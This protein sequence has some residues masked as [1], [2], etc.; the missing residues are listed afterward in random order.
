MKPGKPIGKRIMRSKI[1]SSIKALLKA[2]M[3]PD[4]SIRTLVIFIMYGIMIVASFFSAYLLRF[5]FNFKILG[6][7][8][9][10]GFLFVVLAVK[11]FYLLI[12]GQFKGLMTF[13][14]I[15]DVIKIFW[16]MMFSAVTLLALNYFLFFNAGVPIIPRGVILSD[17][18]LSMVI[19][20]SARI[21]MRMYRERSMVEKGATHSPKR[22]MIIGA[23]DIGTS[24]AADLIARK[25]LGILPVLFLDDDPQKW[26]KQIMGIEVAPLEGNMSNFVSGFKIDRAIIASVRF[27]GQRISKIISA[28]HKIGIETSIV[29]SYHDLASGRVKAS[30][31][32]DVDIEDV[33][34]REPVK[35]DDL[36]IDKMI[37]GKIVMVTGAGGSIGRELCRQIASK[38]PELLIMVDH[39]EVQLFQV[40]QEILDYEFGAKIK[41]LVGNV[42]DEAR[43]EAVISK[44]RP[45]IIFHAAAHKHVPMMESQPGEALK[46]N[47][48]GTWILAGVASRNNVEKFLLIST[49]KAINPTN[50]MGASKRLAEKAIQAMQSR[51][52]NKTIF[53]AVRF[54]NVLGSSGSVIP[55]FKK[56]ISYGGP[57]TVTH[58]EVT[59]YFMTIPEAVGLVLQCA[60]Q[61]YGG[62]IFVLNMGEPVKVIDLARQLIRLSG[63]EPDVD[64]QIKIIG[65]R[66]GE[67]LYEEIQHKNESLVDTPNP[68]IYGFVSEMP[69][70]GEVE[71]IISDIKK[72][73]DTKSVNEL[74]RF[75]F[76]VVPEYKAQFY[77]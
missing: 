19:F 50:V 2:Q 36:A 77:D 60:A 44:Y 11:Y 18:L 21:V 39:C 53:V 45:N 28:L 29:P 59:R 20:G 57:V 71:K 55:T 49:D 40:E 63:L 72:N 58:P 16:V 23:G 8:N 43:M 70:Y 12:F 24:L 4:F 76:T 64:I 22:V 65:L 15:P 62:E 48:L 54:G 1:V 37:Q 75:I 42:A 52:G 74:K 32:R 17:M 30:L 51:P 61:A 25:N 14:H 35:L 7:Y 13:F 9:P 31:L 6:E 56:Q 34:G 10:I 67:K 66:P 69:S 47:T 33:L 5:D 46:N 3:L 38:S 26:G 27:S 73:V 68:R 41:P